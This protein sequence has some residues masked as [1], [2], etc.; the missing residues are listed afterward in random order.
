MELSEIGS[1]SKKGDEASN[2]RDG[3]ARNLINLGVDDFVN[4]RVFEDDRGTV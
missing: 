4:G 3:P 1:P 2:L